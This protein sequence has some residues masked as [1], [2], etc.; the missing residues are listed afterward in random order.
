M[1]CTQSLYKVKYKK[2]ISDPIFLIAI[3]SSWHAFCTQSVKQILQITRRGETNVHER[4]ANRDF[5]ARYPKRSGEAR[6]WSTAFHARLRRRRTFSILHRP[7]DGLVFATLRFCFPSSLFRRNIPDK[8]EWTLRDG[9]LPCFEGIDNSNK[10][11]NL[12]TNRHC[13]VQSYSL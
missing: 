7:Q 1:H 12:I 9:T 2:K 13:I 11:R 6:S 8:V 4:I 10:L 5:L 3:S